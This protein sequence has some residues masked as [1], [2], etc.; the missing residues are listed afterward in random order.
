LPEKELLSLPIA[1]HI[2]H[3]I[4]QD[5]NLKDAMKQVAKDRGVSKSDVY[6]E[7]IKNKESE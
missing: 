7:Y 4:N 6:S 1:D 2:E 3:F 5:L